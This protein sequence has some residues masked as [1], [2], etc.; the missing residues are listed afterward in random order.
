VPPR[1]PEPAH[2][3]P[4]ATEDGRALPPLREVADISKPSTAGG[5]VYLGV[6]AGALTGVVIA[7][8]G[9]WRTGVAWLAV[10]LLV[11]ATAR[12]ALGDDNAGMLRVRR[13]LLDATILVGLG[14]A[15]L[16]LATTIPDQPG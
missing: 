7:A 14:V 3:D 5:V 10:S 4:D 2:P 11:A 9:A 6:L 12:L 13:K 16:F 8:A 1:P 15:L